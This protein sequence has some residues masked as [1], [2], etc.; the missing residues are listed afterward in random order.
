MFR[1]NKFNVF[2]LALAICIK[3]QSHASILYYPVNNEQW[4]IK[5]F[6]KEGPHKLE[7]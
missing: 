7:F 5:N 1:E 2:A 3:L 6:S 4:Q